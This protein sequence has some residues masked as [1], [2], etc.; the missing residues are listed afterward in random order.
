M[1]NIMITECCNLHCPYCFANEFVNKERNYI[2]LDAFNEALAFIKTAKQFD[3]RVG[4]IGGEPTVSPN[5]GKLITLLQNDEQ[6]KRVAVYTNG[7]LLDRFID[8]LIKPKFDFLI[9][10]NAPKDIGNANYDRILEN[11]G[12][13]MKNGKGSHLALGINL[14]EK[15]QDTRYFVKA[16]KEYNITHARLSITTP[17]NGT[18]DEGFRRLIELRSDLLDLTEQL[19]YEHIHFT[20]DCNRVPECVWSELEQMKIDLIHRRMLNKHDLDNLLISC[21][22]PVID[23]LPDLTAIRCFGMSDIS[24]VDIRDFD[25]IDKLEEY[26]RRTIDIQMLEIPVIPTCKNCKLFKNAKCYGGCISN[27]RCC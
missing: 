9:N 6:V 12:M 25:T 16:L 27:K 1:A 23:I 26:Y 11:I 18:S 5:F 10:L 13:L 21:C 7:V 2:Q 19:L 4:L 24:K 22:N 14:Y 8:T 20:I 3:G 17:N 15:N